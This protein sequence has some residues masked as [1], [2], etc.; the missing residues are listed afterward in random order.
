MVTMRVGIGDEVRARPNQHIRNWERSI[1][2]PRMCCIPRKWRSAWADIARTQPCRLFR[3]RV[4]ACAAARCWCDESRLQPLRSAG[5][6]SGPAECL[7]RAHALCQRIRSLPHQMDQK[8]EQSDY[9]NLVATSHHCALR[10][11][12]AVQQAGKFRNPSENHVNS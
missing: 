6:S 7:Q 8:A 4:F 1:A 2:L 9:H 10:C 3:H 11:T 12:A 5:T